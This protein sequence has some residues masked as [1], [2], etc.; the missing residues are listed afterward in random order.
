MTTATADQ[1]TAELTG[2]CRR[3]H[4]ERNKCQMGLTPRRA[5][6][7][8][9]FGWVRRMPCTR[10]PWSQ[11]IAHCEHYLPIDERE[12]H[13]RVKRAEASR[14]SVLLSLTWLARLKVY[15]D[16]EGTRLCPLCGCL[17]TYSIANHHRKPRHRRLTAQCATAGCIDVRQ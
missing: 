12:I 3:Y 4:G 6:G 11:Y 10:R 17:L 16:P 15:G 7:G 2:Q 8:S 14:E 1:L 9:D 5:T 13:Q